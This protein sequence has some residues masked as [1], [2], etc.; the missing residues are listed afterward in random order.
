MLTQAAKLY[1]VEL[2]KEKLPV[3][4][5]LVYHPKYATQTEI[6]AWEEGAAPKP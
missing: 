6:R 2:R 1:D 5:Y 3:T 4:S